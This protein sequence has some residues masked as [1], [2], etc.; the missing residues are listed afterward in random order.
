MT[1]PTRPTAWRCLALL[2]MGLIWAWGGAAQTLEEIDAAVPQVNRAYAVREAEVQATRSALD[3]LALGR[4]M[5]TAADAAAEPAWAAVLRHR[6]CPLLLA[7]PD[8]YASA[9]EAL[10]KLPPALRA[11]RFEWEDRLLG[12]YE[13]RYRAALAAQRKQIGGEYLPILL[14]AADARL[15]HDAD[16][17]MSLLRKAQSVARLS[18]R[19]QE[20]QVLARI[21]E[22]SRRKRLDERRAQLEEKLADEPDDQA[23]R[24]ELVTLLVEAYDASGAARELSRRLDRQNPQAATIVDAM[25]PQRSLSAERALVAAEWWDARYHAAAESAK[26]GLLDSV[27]QAYERVIEAPDARPGSSPVIK[28]TLSLQRVRQRMADR[29]LAFVPRFKAT[30]EIPHEV[31]LIRSYDAGVP[32]RRIV[33]PNEG[34]WAAA[35][36]EGGV[37]QFDLE[38][39]LPVR[40]L[41][42]PGPVTRLAFDPTGLRLTAGG[43]SQAQ[44]D[45]AFAF[46]WQ[47]RSGERMR[48]PLMIPGRCVEIG[49]IQQR[50][51]VGLIDAGVQIYLQDIGRELANAAVN[52]AYHLDWPADASLLAV[53]G[54]QAES[55]QVWTVDPLTNRTQQVWAGARAIAGIRVSPDAITLLL[56]HADAARVIELDSA[57]QRAWLLPPN[58][59]DGSPLNQ[60]DVAQGQ[61]TG[62]RLSALAL[63]PD[64]RRAAIALEPGAIVHLFDTTTGAILQTLEAEP[65]TITGLA[66]SGDGRFLLGAAGQKLHLWGLAP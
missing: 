13:Q 9:A 6:A 36:F 50:P 45:E 37:L 31:G 61:D 15:A 14:R 57:N 26:A 44:P 48:R 42:T 38:E 10:N 41:A 49:Y 25:Q 58:K 59:P 20:A 65:D 24:I 64:G 7:H 33:L 60:A 32:I 2:G 29:G 19:E 4:E 22:L 51:V 17:S 52:N 27:R 3:D 12:L 16:A 34:A 40:K 21:E 39:G 28:A 46:E 66:F 30:L 56:A 63:S 23:A 35:A 55:H 47:V 5:L 54:R 8:G 43:Q 53:G 1:Q 62:W 11:E 18:D